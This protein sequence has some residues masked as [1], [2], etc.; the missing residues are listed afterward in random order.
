M[1]NY[2]VFLVGLI[3]ALSME[4]H[5]QIRVIPM[6]VQAISG[7][8]VSNAKYRLDFTAGEPVAGLIAS[9]NIFINQG[10]QQGLF[11]NLIST[12][13]RE[14]EE[15][16]IR[17]FPNPTGGFFQIENKSEYPLSHVTIINAMGQ[18][19]RVFDLVQPV[20]QIDVSDLSNGFYWVDII[21]R[22]TADCIDNNMSN[23]AVL[24]FL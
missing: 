1:R 23:S 11:Q 8:E 18:A 5:S 12:V 22:C 4:L 17:L 14:W 7:G 16:Y 13:T 10:F 3:I 15:A 19:V 24:Y 21:N 9:E 6:D 20:Q 2:S